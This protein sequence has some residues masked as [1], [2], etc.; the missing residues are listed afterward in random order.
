VP[1]KEIEFLE[2]HA[3]VDHVHMLLSVPPRSSIAMTVG[4]LKGKSAIRIHRDY[5]KVRG[6]C[7]GAVSGR[8][9]TA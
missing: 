8:V 4:Y 6:R 3:M 2:G 5:G 1:Q 7:L 9:G